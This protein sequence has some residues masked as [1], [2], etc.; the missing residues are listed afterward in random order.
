M[1]N[2]NNQR[3]GHQPKR[4]NPWK[5]AFFTIIGL[6]VIGFCGFFIAIHLSSNETISTKQPT[7]SDE[8]SVSVSL[9]KAQLNNLSQYYLNKVQ[10]QNNGQ[11][12]YHFEVA[13]QGIVYGSIK[14]LG[15]DVDYSMFF[16]PKVLANGNVELHATKMSLGKFPVPISF[17]LLNVKHAYK[18]P[19]WVKLIPDKKMIKLDIVHMNGNR[20]L[21]YRARQINLNGQGKFAFDII[22]PKEAQGD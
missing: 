15:S 14:L 22:L 3:T 13:N 19:K 12:K 20:G 11:A 5:M 6:I 9:N 8:R 7:T 2:I 4:R 18:L 21:N 16:T 17:V 10:T 1:I